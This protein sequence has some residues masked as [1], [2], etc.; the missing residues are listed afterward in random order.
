MHQDFDCGV[1]RASL[2]GV[3]HPVRRAV[4][5]VRASPHCLRVLP[6]RSSTDGRV[7]GDVEVASK[8]RREPAPSA[9]PSHASATSAVLECRAATSQLRQHTDGDSRQEAEMQAG[10]GSR[11]VVLK[12]TYRKN[13]T[14]CGND[15]VDDWGC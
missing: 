6:P 2:N 10:Q 5:H 14:L 7:D 1:E 15:V 11:Q 13:V 4:H 8:L 3:D 12:C 9:V